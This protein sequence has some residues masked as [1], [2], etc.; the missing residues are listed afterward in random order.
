MTTLQAQ[1]IKPLPALSGCYCFLND[2]NQIIYIGKAKNIQ[3]RVKQHFT[4]PH[5]LLHNFY[6]EIVKVIFYVTNSEIEALIL[7]QRLIKKHQPLYNV[8]WKD[9]KTYP[10]I[11]LTNEEYPRLIYLRNPTIKQ[12]NGIFFGPFPDGFWARKI[13]NFL[14]AELPFRKCVKLPKKSCIF[15][16]LKQCWA[17][18]INKNIQA[19]DYIPLKDQ[20]T[21][22]FRKKDTSL[23]KKIDQLIQEHSDNL[24]FEKA[25]EYLDLKTKIKSLLSQQLIEIKSQKNYHVLSWEIKDNYLAWTIYFFYQGSFF[26]KTEEIFQIKVDWFSELQLQL[27]NLYSINILPD[28]FICEKEF[29]DA[30]FFHND[31]SNHAKKI[32]ILAPLK[33]KFRKLLDLVNKNNKIYFKTSFEKVVKDAEK[34]QHPLNYL[35]NILQLTH[36]NH[37][38]FIDTSHFCGLNYVGAVISFK[39]NHFFWSNFRKYNLS[40]IITSSNDPLA[41]QETLKKKYISSGSSLVIPDLIIIDGGKQQLNA[42]KK[43]LQ[44]YLSSKIIS[45]SKDAK[46]RSYKLLIDSDDEAILLSSEPKLKNF[47]TL[48]QDRAHNYAIT[49]FRKLS[50]II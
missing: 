33:G 9:D 41:I 6:S 47:I 11:H 17:P 45:V 26:S 22:F 49:Y 30:W 35:K 23:I 16:D 44:G 10:Y 7:E 38:D 4:T 3:K 1:L 2:N 37:I 12:K 13:I 40:E 50:S 36:L 8:L 18:C 25:Q 32:K 43:I 42:A 31:E 19:K 28:I 14:N 48:L 27:S 21:N 20:L 29:K 15:F 34:Y 39:N 5:R 24:D 46:H